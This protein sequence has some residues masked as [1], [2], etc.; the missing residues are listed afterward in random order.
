MKDTLHFQISA[1]RTICGDARIGVKCTDKL[2][3][4]LQSV[5]PETKLGIAADGACQDC[6]NALAVTTLHKPQVAVTPLDNKPV[7][8]PKP[9]PKPEVKEKP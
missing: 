1:T 4:I 2:E 8:V 3:K 5:H 6:A 9:A 7:D